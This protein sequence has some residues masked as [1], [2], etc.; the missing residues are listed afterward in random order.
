MTFPH[1]SGGGGGGAWREGRGWSNLCQQP[2]HQTIVNVN[3]Y[4]PVYFW[5]KHT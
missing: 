4:R 1:Y 2:T 5:Y 3:T